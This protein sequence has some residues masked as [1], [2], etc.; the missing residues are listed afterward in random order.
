MVVSFRTSCAL[1]SGVRGSRSHEGG[2]F[3]RR[4]AAA[5]SVTT[6]TAA[7]Q[8]RA[9]NPSCR[10]ARADARTAATPPSP[11]VEQLACAGAPRRPAAGATRRRVAA[12]ALHALTRPS[13]AR[14]PALPLVM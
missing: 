1:V 3:F 6:P 9:T 10:H 2:R 8:P 12:I 14:D 4:V 5:L 11:E 13:D 7:E